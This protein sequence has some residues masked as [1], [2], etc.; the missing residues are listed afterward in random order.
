MQQEIKDEGTKLQEESI[1]VKI[2]RGGI[3][4]RINF[5]QD[6]IEI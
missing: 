5:S 6:N 3:F 2:K 4:D 1:D